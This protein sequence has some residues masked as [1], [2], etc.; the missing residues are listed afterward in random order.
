[1]SCINLLDLSQNQLE[2]FIKQL[3]QPSF[4]A[5]QISKW[6]YSGV[7]DFEEMTNLPASLR[8]QL[9]KQAI[10]GL[11]KIQDCRISEIDETRKYVFE[12]CDGNIIESVLMKYKYGYSV[13]VSSQVGCKMGCSFCASTGAGFSRNLTAGEIIG[14]IL[15]INRDANVK[16]GNI[17]IMG[18]GEPLDNY[19]NII[20]FL[21]KAQSPEGLGISYRRIALST[22]GLVPGIL[23]LNKEDLPITLSI[24]LHSPFD[25][26]RS[27]MMPVNRT[28]SIDKLLE[29]CN[30]YTS[31]TNRRITFE[32]AMI[33]GVNDTLRHATELAKLIEGMLCHVNL[34]PINKVVGNNYKRSSKE[35]VE[36]FS[37]VL[38]KSGI[39]VTVRRE[40]GRDINA[41][42]GQLRRSITNS[43]E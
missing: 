37:L 2:E 40:L 24:S 25:E 8:E 23:K 22:C 1:M 7:V 11:L 32:Y 30:I 6:L 26:E 15:T 16:I 34:I 4:R 36:N 38:N 31:G 42:C 13:C 28:Y 35:Q 20:N 17:V 9:S 29:A 41:A 21:K 12:L 39:E 33:S 27:E 5:K 14:Q 19:D 43:I 3:Q 18:I 10:T